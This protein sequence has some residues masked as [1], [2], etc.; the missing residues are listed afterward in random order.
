MRS[1]RQ[2]RKEQP[3]VVED[4]SQV[5]IS[6]L[7]EAAAILAN[8]RIGAT[9]MKNVILQIRSEFAGKLVLLGACA[10][11]F[12]AA[13]C[14]D[15]ATDV[16]APIPAANAG[17]VVFKPDAEA[18]VGATV[19]GDATKIKTLVASKAFGQR[20]D[21]F[22]LMPV[23]RKREQS[24]LAE[25][26]TSESG[27]STQFEPRVEVDPSQFEIDDPQPYRRLAG[28]IIGDTVMAIMMMEDGHAEIIRPGMMIPNTEW[29]VVS[30][31]EE[32]AV[33]RRAGNKRPRQIVVNLETDPGGMAPRGGTGGNSGGGTGG[34]FNGRGGRGGI[35]GDSDR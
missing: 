6:R 20:S 22:A 16:P 8:N 27:W 21:I 3:V 10:T 30:I 24:M 7:E 19:A 9:E 34:G 29:R 18:G 25:R 12:A 14:N 33:L 2:F 13:G 15:V 17:T 35:G 31:D 5:V 4:S 32:K 11:V 26:L 1:S 23:E 28:V